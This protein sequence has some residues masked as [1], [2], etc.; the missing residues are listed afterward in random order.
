VSDVISTFFTII[1][2]ST[3]LKYFADLEE[4]IVYYIAT[5]TSFGIVIL[6]G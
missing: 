6:T 4:R 3:P 1:I 5:T 2:K